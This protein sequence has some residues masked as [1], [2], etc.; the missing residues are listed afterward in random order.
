MKVVRKI[1]INEE[2]HDILNKF[3]DLCEDLELYG[4]DIVDLLSSICSDEIDFEANS[5]L[6]DIEYTDQGLYSP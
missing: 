3:H 4:L 1:T 2:E 5:E 6:Y